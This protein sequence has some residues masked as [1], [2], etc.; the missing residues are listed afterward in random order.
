VADC[1]N[2]CAYDAFIAR[3]PLLHVLYFI[4]RTLFITWSCL[5]TDPQ[6]HPKR[7]LHRV[8]SKASSFRFQHLFSSTRPSIS[9]LHLLPR[10]SVLFTLQ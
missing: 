8:R 3:V 5:A 9:C 1:N 7:I 2:N 4:V 6:T 10:L